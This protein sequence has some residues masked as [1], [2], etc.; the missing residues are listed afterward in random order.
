MT[1]L[2]VMTILGT[3]PE[4]IRL[5]E[6]MK[7]LDRYV[8]HILVHTNQNYDYELNQI[9]FEELNLR[10]PDY[11][12]SVK[13]SSVGGQIGNILSQTEE[14]I[15]KEKPD[16]V[17]ILG[18]TNSALSCIVA[19]RLKIPVFHMEAGNRCFDDRVPEEINRRIVDHTSDI[20]LPYT[21]YAR[22]NLL[23]EGV[24][25]DSIFV[26][27]SPLREVLERYK[28]KI[29]SSSVLDELGLEKE[30]YFLLSFHR[31]E[32]VD[33]ERNLRNIVNTL[34]NLAE[35][36]GYPLIISTH[37]RT[38]MKLQDL[39]ISDNKLFNF[40]KPFGMFDYVNLQKNAYCV[41]SDSGTIH[42]EAAILGIPS[43]VIRES[44]ERPEVFDTG[45]VILTGMDSQTILQSIEVARKQYEEN[46]EFATPEAYQNTNVSDRVLKLIIGMSKLIRKKKYYLLDE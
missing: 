27:G 6:I 13:S 37:P 3:R 11:V 20:N 40:H 16:A 8:D 45:N 42:E 19:K 7:K 4:I 30:K 31:E 33:K 24:D 15:L 17:L 44:T 14:V 35:K 32:N 5:S 1:N 36:Y 12:L 46:I 2:K 39:E 22:R 10:N 29:D 25:S 26:V 28:G 41:L 21:E 34:E 9:F 23:R 18:D 38:K 43:L